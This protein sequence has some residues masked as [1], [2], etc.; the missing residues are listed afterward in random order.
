MRCI[1][2]T[3]WTDNPQLIKSKIEEVLPDFESITIVPAA[4]TVQ[5]MSTKHTLGDMFMLAHM[6]A[7]LTDG[8]IL[9]DVGSN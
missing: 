1:A 5:V 4:E 7:K 6:L 8:R 9:V 2:V 3:V